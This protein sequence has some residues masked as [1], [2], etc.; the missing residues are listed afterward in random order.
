MKID[1]LKGLS[2]RVVSPGLILPIGMF[3]WVALY[4]LVSLLEELAV[5]LSGW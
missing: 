2:L 1:I 3:S 4:V 5:A